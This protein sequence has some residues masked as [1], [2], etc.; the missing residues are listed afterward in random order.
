M[1]K[2][3]WR[4]PC[5]FWMGAQASLGGEMTVVS[6]VMAWAFCCTY[7]CLGLG[8]GVW[9]VLL[10]QVLRFR[11]EVCS[12]PVTPSLRSRSFLLVWRGLCVK[13]HLPREGPPLQTSQSHFLPLGFCSWPHS[14]FLRSPASSGGAAEAM[15]MSWCPSS[16]WLEHGCILTQKPVFF[17]CPQILPQNCCLCVAWYDSLS[18]AEAVN[19][20]SGLCWS[21]RGS[22]LLSAS[23]WPLLPVT[24]GLPVVVS[25]IWWQCQDGIE[26]QG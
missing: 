4:N 15:F 19:L 26:A 2:C 10:A 22:I 14:P 17:S 12:P 3:P 7:P 8:T 25:E 6:E 24:A 16:C 13:G 20:L 1:K 18:M 21:L 9:C 23:R 11:W 5:M